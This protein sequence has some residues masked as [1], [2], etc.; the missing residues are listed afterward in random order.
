MQVINGYSMVRNFTAANAGFCKWGFAEKNGN[1]YFI[2]EFLS[3]KYPLDSHT[4]SAQAMARKKQECTKFYSER[5]AFYEV[6]RSCDT[7]NV[8]IVREFFREGSRYYAVTEKVDS[9]RYTVEQLCERL[10]IAQAM[11]LSPLPEAMPPLVGL[12]V[13]SIPKAA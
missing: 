3:P 4:L 2:K 8:V 5:S 9:P 11:A 7:G 1:T 12:W 13:C 6:V 10:N